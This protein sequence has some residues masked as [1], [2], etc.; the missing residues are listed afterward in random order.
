MTL[1]ERIGRAAYTG[2]AVARDF[3]AAVLMVSSVSRE[4]ANKAR[5]AT[6]ANKEGVLPP[7]YPGALGETHPSD[8][9]GLGKESGD[10]EYAADSVMTLVRDTYDKARRATPMWLAVAK[11]RAGEPSWCALEFNGSTFSPAASTELNEVTP[12]AK[13]R[14]RGPKL[15]SV[16]LPD[17]EGD[18]R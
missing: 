13:R 14:T 3:G 1:R 15:R 12:D 8:L 6:E 2:R 5:V 4:S 10:I 11:V 7:G 18:D 16:E 17:L 9:V